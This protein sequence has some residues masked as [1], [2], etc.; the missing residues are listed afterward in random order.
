M[1]F[2]V[3]LDNVGK[4]ETGKN[5]DLQNEDIVTPIFKFRVLKT[6]KRIILTNHIVSME[7][8]NQNIGDLIFNS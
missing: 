3:F 2:F 8:R 1:Y 7:T 4:K 5:L 6:S